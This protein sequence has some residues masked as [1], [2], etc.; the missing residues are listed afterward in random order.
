MLFLIGCS[1]TQIKY[2]E[3]NY[4]EFAIAEVDLS[5]IPELEPKYH[6]SFLENNSSMVVM[7]TWFYVKMLDV[8]DLRKKHLKIYKK[9][10]GWALEDVQR[11]NNFV[12]EQKIKFKE[13]SSN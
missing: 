12:K 10:Y 7:P 5:P 2:Y 1:S 6:V 11:Y 8:N 13:L 9:F 3:P 4:Y